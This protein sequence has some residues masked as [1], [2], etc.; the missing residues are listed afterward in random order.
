MANFFRK[1]QASIQ[2]ADFIKKPNGTAHIV[3][4]N[5]FWGSVNGNATFSPLNLYGDLSLINAQGK[6]AANVG[7]VSLTSIFANLAINGKAN[8]VA[9]VFAINSSYLPSQAIGEARANLLDM[10]TTANFISTSARGVASTEIGVFIG[11]SSIENGV[12]KGKANS[13]FANFDLLFN[14]T[15]LTAGNIVNLDPE[16]IY[17][18]SL[19]VFKV[20]KKSKITNNY[21]FKSKTK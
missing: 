12:A 21:F 17:A 14:L 1:T 16:I 10:Q 18:K 4:N 5:E 15:G 11:N 19:M 7:A 13:V 8:A 2:I 20:F 9:G 3:V 6:A